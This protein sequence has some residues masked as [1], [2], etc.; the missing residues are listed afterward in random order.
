M[1]VL[2]MD[3][4]SSVATVSIVSDEKVEGEIYLN[5]KMQHSVILFPMIEKLLD[6]TENKLDDI[7]IIAVSGGP[8]SFTGLRIGVAAAKGIVQ[9]ANK[10]F[11]TVS[12]LEAMAYQQGDF[13]GV[14]CP[15]MD[16]LRDNVYTALYQFK[17]GEL[18]NIMSI[19]A[20]HID[21]LLDKLE[22]YDR[23]LFCGDAVS[24]HIGRIKDRLKE[25]AYFSTQNNMLPRASS[26]GEIAL[27]KYRKGEVSDIYT[28]SPLYIRK[29]QAEREY[30]KRTGEK[31]E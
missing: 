16:A 6:I 20:L 1:K 15:I 8:G 19:D 28:F 12:S 21:E 5:H 27:K 10:I 30:E 7:D 24:I 17:E 3:T 13:E 9:G 26:I 29:S 31:L 18:T 14:I 2:A 4:S 11:I 23:V 25:R 22:A